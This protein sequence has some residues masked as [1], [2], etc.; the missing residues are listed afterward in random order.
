M[1]AAP[2]L[3]LSACLHHLW[4]SIRS[5]HKPHSVL[6][7]APGGIFGP[8]ASFL[9]SSP[10]GYAPSALAPDLEYN[11]QY[12]SGPALAP[13]QGLPS[14]LT[15]AEQIGTNLYYV[16]TEENRG[17][18][19]VRLPHSNLVHKCYPRGMPP[20]AALWPWPIA[21]ESWTC[22]SR[23]TCW[24]MPR[25]SVMPAKVD[26]H[27]VCTHKLKLLRLESVLLPRPQEWR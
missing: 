2:H 17:F 13:A 14:W 11:L 5:T 26:Q 4:L 16:G 3:P 18:Y 8:Q 22:L 23:G 10:V 20:G 27:Q 25:Q 1:S 24:L 15:N 19:T 9:A 6:A 12:Y 7:A 21:H